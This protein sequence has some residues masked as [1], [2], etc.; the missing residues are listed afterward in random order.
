MFQ[1]DI[2]FN[3]V[4]VSP[5]QSG[6]KETILKLIEDHETQS[7]AAPFFYMD[8]LDLLKREIPEG[9]ALA[10]DLSTV[11]EEDKIRISAIHRYNEACRQFD[12]SIKVASLKGENIG[13]NLVALTAI[14]SSSDEIQLLE[15]DSAWGDSPV[16]LLVTPG[17]YYGADYREFTLEDIDEAI[18]FVEKLGNDVS[19]EESF[20][21]AD[22]DGLTKADPPLKGE[23][24]ISHMQLSGDK[25]EHILC[26]E[27]GYIVEDE[28]GN[29]TP[30]L[31]SLMMNMF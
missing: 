17:S 3:Y 23:E 25:P 16:V 11:V 28:K 20:T 5:G 1:N 4:D 9:W 10:V 21:R 13:G 6:L 8:E 26:Y 18:D 12:E 2:T 24:L 29:W 7:I 14:E 27:A 31:A 19:S 15:L 30:D 22:V